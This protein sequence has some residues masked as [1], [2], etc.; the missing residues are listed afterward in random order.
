MK[1]KVGDTAA[2]ADEGVW[3]DAGSGDG[4]GGIEPP[5]DGD[6][7]TEAANVGVAAGA[8]ARDGEGGTTFTVVVKAEA[9]GEN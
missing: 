9:A 8:N 1:E 2:A 6:T 5:T 4:V 7:G 3:V